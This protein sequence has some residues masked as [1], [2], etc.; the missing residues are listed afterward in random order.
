M[1]GGIQFTYRGSSVRTYF[2]NPKAVVPI[3]KK[4]GN[5]ELKTWGRRKHQ[6]GHLP[7][8]GW[9]RLES[10][11]QGVWDKWFPKPIKIIVDQF[12]EKDIESKSHWFEL[13][14]GQFIQG[15]LARYE[16]E[17]RIYIVTIVPEM[18]DAVHDRWPRIMNDPKHRNNHHD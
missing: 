17:S 3:L 14:K 12:M 6:L 2:P 9:A 11:Q 18:P 5:I 7:L 8:G 15:L 10:I 4:D 16:N 1:C 13:P